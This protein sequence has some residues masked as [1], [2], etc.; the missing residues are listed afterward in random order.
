MGNTARD[1]EFIALTDRY[2]KDRD[3]HWKILYDRQVKRER[4]MRERDDG[5]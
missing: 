3:A 1:R 5:R 2:V 4:A